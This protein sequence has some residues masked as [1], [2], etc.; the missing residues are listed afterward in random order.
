MF[1][2]D[3]R[4]ASAARSAQRPARREDG[5]TVPILALEQLAEKMGQSGGSVDEFPTPRGQTPIKAG[6]AR[7]RASFFEQFAG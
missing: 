4:T 2:Y 7:T 6:S 1:V 3:S 5:A